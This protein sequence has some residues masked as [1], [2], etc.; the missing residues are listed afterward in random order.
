MA[1][2]ATDLYCRFSSEHRLNM[3]ACKEM[4]SVATMT[5]TPEESRAN[6]DVPG[7]K[8]IISASGMASGGRVIHHLSQYISDPKNHNFGWISG[9]WHARTGFR[10]RLLN[11]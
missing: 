7:P 3:Q 9:R 11:K 2:N 5:R 10:R 4:C 1:I 6:Y 8:I